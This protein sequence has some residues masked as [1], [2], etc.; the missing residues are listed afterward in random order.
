MS[1]APGEVSAY[2]PPSGGLCQGG[3]G[4]LFQV[5]ERDVLCPQGYTQG[6]SKVHRL[7]VFAGLL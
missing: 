7:L 5:G 3:G 4:M 6:S 1:A 2:E